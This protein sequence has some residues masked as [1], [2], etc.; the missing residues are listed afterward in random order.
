MRILLMLFILMIIIVIGSLVL[1][2]TA[3][4]HKEVTIIHSIVI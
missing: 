3:E 2:F 1:L 4:V